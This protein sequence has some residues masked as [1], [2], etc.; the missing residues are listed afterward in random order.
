M[1]RLYLQQEVIMIVTKTEECPECE[2]DV[3]VEID[4]TIDISTAAHELL[5]T[6]CGSPVHAGDV[7]KLEN[8][9]RKCLVEEI[10]VSSSVVS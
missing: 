10:G 1:P 8:A 6:Y 4:V 3:D 2:C 7:I 5:S 9:I